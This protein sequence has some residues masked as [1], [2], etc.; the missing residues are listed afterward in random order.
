M[1]GLESRSCS[2]LTAASI[3]ALLFAGCDGHGEEPVDAWSWV[4]GRQ[5]VD[6]RPSPPDARPQPDSSGVDAVTDCADD[7]EPN[8]SSPYWLGVF[9]DHP[10]TDQTFT[11]FNLHLQNDLDLYSIDVVD[12]GFDGNADITITLTVPSDDEYNLIATGLC[13]DG[14]EVTS[15][16]CLEGEAVAGSNSCRSLPGQAAVEIVSMELNCASTSTD[17]GSVGIRIEGVG[18]VTT[19]AAYSMQISVE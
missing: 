9:T 10:D 16:D 2:F 13:N 3:V 18:L 15:V 6:A 17:S 5:R 8:D 11:E 1:T 14:V 4:D 7:G 19:C 12:A